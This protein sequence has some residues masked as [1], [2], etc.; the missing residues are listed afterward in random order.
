VIGAGLWGALGY[1]A[2][3]SPTVSISGRKMTNRG[4]KVAIST[5]CSSM[6]GMT[7]QGKRLAD[8]IGCRYGEQEDADQKR[9][10]ERPA[11][12]R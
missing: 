7:I 8:A 4:E 6:W 11:C 1:I 9:S 2:G 12:R 5:I 10:R 3:L